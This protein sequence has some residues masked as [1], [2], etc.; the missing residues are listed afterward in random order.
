[1]IRAKTP[2][3]LPT[4]SVL[5]GNIARDRVI[6]LELPSKLAPPTEGFSRIKLEG[7]CFMGFI[8]CFNLKR[9]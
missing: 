1:M 9:L 3:Q 5:H 7:C 4:G 2:H 8:F 6:C